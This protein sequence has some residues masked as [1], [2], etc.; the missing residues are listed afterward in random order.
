MAI[1]PA[2]CGALPDSGWTVLNLHHPRG[3]SIVRQGVWSPDHGSVALCYTDGGIDFFDPLSKNKKFVA[4]ALGRDSED[5]I[6]WRPDGTLIAAGDS[7]TKIVYPKTGKVVTLKA[8]SFGSDS[9]IS[10]DCK[11]VLNRGYG[12]EPLEVMEVSSCK[13]ISSSGPQEMMPKGTYSA[14]INR[15]SPDSTMFVATR[16]H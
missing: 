16:G 5:R 13:R 4:G 9:Q 15:W 14:Q 11:F 12:Y 7:A 3:E 10:P 8:V 1:G 6:T 2:M